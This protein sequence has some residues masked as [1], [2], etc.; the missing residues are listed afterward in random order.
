[1][2]YPP[3]EV[4]AG[5]EQL[6]R[7]P[8][9]KFLQQVLLEEVLGITGPGQQSSAVNFSEGRRSFAAELIKRLKFEPTPQ[10]D[11]P[12]AAKLIRGPERRERADTDRRS[13]RRRSADGDPE[14]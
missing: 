10:N 12:D 4:A 2:N 1:M 7:S 8:Y 9:A 6:G 14:F 11:G 5:I 13:L 3:D